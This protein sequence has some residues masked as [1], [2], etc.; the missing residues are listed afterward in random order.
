[1]NGTL[2]IFPLSS[3]PTPSLSIRILVLFSHFFPQMT[4]ILK[5][6]YILLVHSFILIFLFVFNLNLYLY[7][8]TDDISISLYILYLYLCISFCLSLSIHIPISTCMSLYIY[9][10]VCIYTIFIKTFINNF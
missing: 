1:M 6:M 4:T 9:V 3:F 5:L 8:R 7:L 2:Q 10:C